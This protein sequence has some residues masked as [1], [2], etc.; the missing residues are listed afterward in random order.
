MHTTPSAPADQSVW[1]CPE[2]DVNALALARSSA[3]LGR[4]RSGLGA[5]IEIA[6]RLLRM[7]EDPEFEV[8]AVARVIEEDPALT[9]RVLRA[10]NGA[11]F[12]LRQ[13]CRHVSHA[14]TMLG[15]RTM[16]ELAAA[17]A[18]AD[19]FTRRGLE[20]R[21]RTHAVATAAVARDL[22]TQLGRPTR[23]LFLSG[24][25][26]D[27]GKL[28][29]LQGAGEER[30]GTEGLRYATL[31][32][33][34]ADV[35]GGTWLLEQASLGFDHA[36]LGQA[37]LEA[38]NIPSPI[39]AVVGWHHDVPRA[40]R[41]GGHEAELVCM[42]RIA[43]ALSHLFDG[44]LR[45]DTTALTLLREPAALSGLGLTIDDLERA[46]PRLRC[47]HANAAGMLD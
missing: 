7:L 47:V 5:S 39:P 43:D 3:Q 10:A 29:L 9:A 32:A 35:A 11:M 15:A 42:L 46:M 45:D 13:P 30:Y 31:L 33:L 27:V 38:W 18:A 19:L 40:L 12:T 24:L 23:D 28:V 20:G 1:F 44:P 34:R 36:A 8:A 37:A 6:A 21:L 41:G 17:A 16:G 26:H 4:V 25:L 22:A 14:I 2:P